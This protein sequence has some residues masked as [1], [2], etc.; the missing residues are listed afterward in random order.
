MHVIRGH[1]LFGVCS[2][3]LFGQLETQAKLTMK[4]L[5]GLFSKDKK[6][7]ENQVIVSR[8]QVASKYRPSFHNATDVQLYVCGSGETRP[9]GSHQTKIKVPIFDCIKFEDE[10]IAS[11][12][13]DVRCCD[14]MGLHFIFMATY[15][16]Q[17]S[18]NQ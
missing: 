1:L 9:I 12:I 13:K 7:D 11:Q 18:T 17:A 5:F 4:K 3:L 10:M 14:S 16:L 15:V 2:F 6:K 8:N